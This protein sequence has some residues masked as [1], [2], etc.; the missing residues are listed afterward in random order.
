MA[1]IAKV[2]EWLQERLGVEGISLDHRKWQALLADGVAPEHP[3]E[4]QRTAMNA[5]RAHGGPT[6]D[7]GS[8]STSWKIAVHAGFLAEGC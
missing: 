3:M 4:E 5:T 8:G 1:A 2:T 6:G 7:E